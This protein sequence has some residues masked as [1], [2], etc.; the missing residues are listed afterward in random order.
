MSKRK[1]EP[2]TAFKLWLAGHGY[3]YKDVAECI[4]CTESTVMQKISGASD[5]YANELQAICSHLGCPMRLFFDANV[6]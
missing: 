3:V 5:F 2:Y 1:H 6:A 4:D